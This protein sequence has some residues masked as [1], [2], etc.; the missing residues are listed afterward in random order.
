MQITRREFFQETKSVSDWQEAIALSA[1]PLL[2]AGYITEKYIEAMYE[3]VRTFGDYIVLVPGFA[4]PH[5]APSEEVK[6]TS[7]ALLKLEE[8]VYFSENP[9]SFAKIILPIACQDSDS[10]I[11]M[12]SMIAAVLGDD[13][14]R[15]AMLK[16]DDLDALYALFVENDKQ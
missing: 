15:E 3:T 8:E 1:Q 16:L 11:D 12:M 4:M 14:K 7:F 10:H 2:D 5:A 6:K 9:D 13:E